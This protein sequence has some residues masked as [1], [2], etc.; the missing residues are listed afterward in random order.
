MIELFLVC[1]MFAAAVCAGYEM[2]WGAQSVKH[3][4]KAAATLGTA[5]NTFGV[6]IVLLVA[7]V[8]IG[9]VIL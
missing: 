3:P 1:A 2:M 7:C 9:L 5:D 8:A 4:E 6:M